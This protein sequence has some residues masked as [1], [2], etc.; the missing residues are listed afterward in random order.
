VFCRNRIADQVFRAALLCHQGVA[1]TS[2]AGADTRLAADANAS[3]ADTRP[4]FTANSLLG[5]HARG[6][7]VHAVEV[8][9]GMQKRGGAGSRTVG[10]QVG[11]GLDHLTGNLCEDFTPGVRRAVLWRQMIA[12]G[13]SRVRSPCNEA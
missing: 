9:R 7:V 11:R 1:E 5:R 3:T 4:R 8:T 2:H 13:H 10:P 12:G 6:V